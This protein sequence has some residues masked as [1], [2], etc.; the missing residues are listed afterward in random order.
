[1]LAGDGMVEGGDGVGDGPGDTPN[2]G[3]SNAWI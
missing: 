1:M 3:N 2:L